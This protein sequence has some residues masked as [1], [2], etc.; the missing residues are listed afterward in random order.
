[1]ARIGSVYVNLQVDVGQMTRFRTAATEV[2]HSGRRMRAALNSTSASVSALRGQMSMPY[3]ARLFGESL[4]TIT[5]TNDEI[6]RLRASMVALAAITGTGFTGALS[7][8]YLVQT[9]D[10][11]RLL[12]NQLKT[13]TSDH[14]DLKA[15]QESLFQVSQRTRSSFDATTKIYA[16]TAR[17]TEHLGMKQQEL[18]RITE[19]VQKAFAIGGATQQEATGAAI[20]LSQG[21]A[22]NRFS[23]DEFRSVAE[24]APVL[25]Q[26][27]AKSLGVNIGK[28]REMAHAGELTADVVTRAILQASGAIDEQFGKMVSTVG[29]GMTLVDNAFIQYIGNVDESYG[30]TRTMAGGLKNLADNFESVAYWIDK[31]ALA[32]LAWAGGR[33]L[34]T[35]TASPFKKF[36]EIRQGS[37]DSLEAARKEMDRINMLQKEHA[38]G[39]KEQEKAL[40]TA[41]Q[42][43]TMLAANDRKRNML[44]AE[45]SMQMRTLN[46]LEATQ[47]AA[48][49]KKEQLAR[50][51]AKYSKELTAAKKASG[52]GTTQGDAVVAATMKSTDEYSKAVKKLRAEEEALRKTRENGVGASQKAAAA[53]KKQ[54]EAVV[55]AAMAY[56]RTNADWTSVTKVQQAEAAKMTALQRDNAKAIEAMQ[57]RIDRQRQVV[58]KRAMADTSN[59]NSAGSRKALQQYEQSLRKLRTLESEGVKLAEKHAKAV[60]RLS[61]ASKARVDAVGQAQLDRATAAYDKQLA[62]VQKLRT[63]EKSALDISK[64]QQD[65]YDAAAQKVEQRRRAVVTA[66]ISERETLAV[67]QRHAMAIKDQGDRVKALTAIKERTLAVDERISASLNDATRAVDVQ[68]ARI[69]EIDKQLKSVNVTSSK[70]EAIANRLANEQRRLNSMQ[71]ESVA[72]QEAHEQATQRLAVA[73]RMATRQAALMNLARRAGGGVVNFFGG[74]TGVALTAAIAGMAYFGRESAKAAEEVDRITRKLENMGYLTKGA[75]DEM[76]N[77]QRSIVEGRISKLQTEVQDLDKYLETRKA[78]IAALSLVK[79]DPLRSPLGNDWNSIEFQKAFSEY[80]KVVALF[81][82]GQK[83]IAKNGEL[84]DDLRMKIER[85][86][87]SN[88]AMS[89]VIDQFMELVKQIEGAVKATDQYRES[90][91]KLSSAGAI[92]TPA[93]IRD[94]MFIDEQGKNTA[95]LQGQSALENL[96]DFDKEVQ[97]RTDS[98]MKAAEA[99]GIAIQRAQA[100][101]YARRDAMQEVASRKGLLGLLGVAEGTDKGRGYN[102]TLDYGKWTGDLNLVAMT[103][104]EILA[105]Q[106][107]MLAN[108]DNLA[109]YGGQGSSAMGR[110][111]ITRRTMLGLMKELGLTGNEYFTPELQDRM[112]EQLMRRRGRNVAGLRNEWEGLRGVGSETI[113]K[114]FD[115][116]ATSMDPVDEAVTKNIELKEKQKEVIDKLL[117][118]LKDETDKNELEA[119]MLKKTNEE[120]IKALKVLEI[121]QNLKR[122]G[123][124]ISATLAEQI[125]REA[126]A[127]AKHAVAVEAAKRKHKE[128]EKAQREGAKAMEEFGGELGGIFREIANGSVDWV[129]VAIKALNALLQY[130]NKVNLAQGGQGIFGG[131]F[132]QALIG[133]FLGIGLP[134]ASSGGGLGGVASTAAAPAGI[135]LASPAA[136]P[137]LAMASG[138]AKLPMTPA[139]MNLPSAGKKEPV[140]ININVNGARGNAEIEEMVKSGVAKGLTEYDRKVVPDRVDYVSKNP[141]IRN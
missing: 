28:L 137:S 11:A 66:A 4:R 35:L 51:Q 2:E 67:A 106:K 113:L 140:E 126:E 74:W 100:E 37:K 128:F 31:A 129:S 46:D 138:M 108:P 82:E 27:I 93:W 16:R 60:E 61:A 105:V 118:S 45:R 54:E 26:G 23:G 76:T 8:A 122:Q 104:K 53:V 30:L 79:F 132:F 65:A 32:G 70:R 131:G 109:K 44:L 6:Q 114:A 15:V 81:R 98:I 29:Q 85:I 52:A 97:K 116:S 49:L 58:T 12:S 141:R 75:A 69:A 107:E 94:A 36:G 103:L 33:T 63:V 20:Q 84:S 136:L 117:A 34:G 96:S 135:G 59:L 88:P 77:L 42:R 89:T 48:E 112:A 90:I 125:D 139:N 21:I 111:Q 83:E 24:N 86:S 73:Q 43:T 124:E 10:R 17:A 56:R 115:Q 47:V 62:A 95:W 87:L 123:I 13:V 7:A 91:G 119:A 39:L 121:T 134:G 25:L 130:L 101:F 99:A 57:A 68:R 14:A 1:M 22:S 3:R 133:G 19:T 102:E 64:A 55:S 50:I 71:K 78:A 5:R 18:L 40:V 38:A 9:A 72:L 127:F 110:Y 41:A 120:R 80:R 92:E